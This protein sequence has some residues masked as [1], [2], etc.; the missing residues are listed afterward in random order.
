MRTKRSKL[1]RFSY[2]P[3]F[4]P[5]FIFVLFT[6]CQ[7][8]EIGVLTKW[9]YDLNIARSRSKLLFVCNIFWFVQKRFVCTYEN[10]ICYYSHFAKWLLSSSDKYKQI[11]RHSV[12]GIAIS[13]TKWTLMNPLKVSTKKTWKCTRDPEG[14]S[15]TMKNIR[16]WST[17][18]RVINETR[19]CN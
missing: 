2:I 10:N 8:R 9:L 1:S 6:I 7:P 18:S 17:R 11:F 13:L 12:A 15:K 4:S 5:I 19:D 14:F 16:N 3:R